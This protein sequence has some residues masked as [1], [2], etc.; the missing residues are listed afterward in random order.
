MIQKK[1]FSVLVVTLLFVGILTLAARTQPVTANGAVYIRADGTIDPPIARGYIQKDVDKYTFTN[2]IY[3]SI[4]IERDNVVVDG[5]GY[6]LQGTGN[7]TGIE[8]SGRNNITIRN[9][10]IKEF[11]HGI[12]LYHSSSV[13][14]YGNEIEENSPSSPRADGIYLVESTN[15]I[16]FQN[17]ITNNGDGIE[18]VAH[19]SNN[20]ILQNNITNNYEGIDLWYSSH[21]TILR[22]EIT[23]NNWDGIEIFQS[24]NNTISTNNVAANF[25]DGIKIHNSSHN[26]ILGNNITNNGDGI[27]LVAHSSNN[28]IL[29]N[30]ITNNMHGIDLKD[31]SNLNTI[32]KNDITKNRSAVQLADSSNNTVSENHIAAINHGFYLDVWSSNNTFYANKIAN[33]RYGT[34]LEFS[35]NNLFY[36]N[37]FFNNT[38]QANCDQS[39]NV[40][41]NGVEGNYWSD[42]VGAD[43]ER[44]G[45][46]DS[47]H[48]INEGNQ[49][50]YPL[51]KPYVDSNSDGQVNIVDLYVIAKAFGTS[52]G[53]PNYDLHGDIDW[54]NTVNILDLYICTSWFQHRWRHP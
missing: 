42:Y 21:N 10:K 18:L 50:N 2:N 40:W 35:P 41:D 53:D 31:S 27:E 15:N 14:I 33:S 54:N 12:A 43:E 32:F 25:Y 46:G 48:V 28:H 22:N 9:V 19:S 3:G 47:P 13:S 16:M 30:N 45:I 20:H 11:Y 1:L 49:D 7:G 23:A 4:V 39:L 34:F 44:D 5:A 17:N 29:Q 37:C 52:S 8:L 24:V 38:I 6:T 26:T 51:M 36:H